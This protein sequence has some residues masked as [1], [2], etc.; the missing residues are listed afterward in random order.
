MAALKVV[1]RICLIVG[2][3]LQISD[4]EFSYTPDIDKVYHSIPISHDAD[5]LVLQ[6]LHQREFR[7]ADIKS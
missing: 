2:I 1:F 6:M 4:A 5:F 3:F 7:F